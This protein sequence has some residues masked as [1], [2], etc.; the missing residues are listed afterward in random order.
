MKVAEYLSGT[1]AVFGLA[2]LLRFGAIIGG[3]RLGGA[4]YDH[5]ATLKDPTPPDQALLRHWQLYR[6][7]WKPCLAVVLPCVAVWLALRNR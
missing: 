2:Y 3:A 6:K 7:T 1:V 5:L 4:K